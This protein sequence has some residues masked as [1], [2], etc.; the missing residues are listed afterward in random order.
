[1]IKIFKTHKDLFILIGVFIVISSLLILKISLNNDY[2]PDWD[3]SLH[4]WMGLMFNKDIFSLDLKAL[5]GLFN[6]SNQLYPPFY[7][8][9]L[10]LW[11]QLSDVKNATAVVANIPFILIL[12]LSVYGL[13]ITLGNKKAGLLAAILSPLLPI[14]ITLQER[15]LIDYASISMFILSFYILFKT[16]GFT[17]KKYSIF[18][19][20]LILI[21]LLIKWPF[22]I[23]AIPFIFYAIYNFNLKKNQRKLIALNIFTSLAI[24]IPG[25]LWYLANYKSIIDILSFFWKPNG[26]AMSVWNFPHGLSFQNII[27]YLYTYPA[28][29]VGLIVLIFFSIQFLIPKVGSEIKFINLSILI[30]FFVLTYLN[31]K[32]PFYFGYAYPLLMITTTT[33]LYS[34][35][36]KKNRILSIAIL[37]LAILGNYLLTLNNTHIY[38]PVVLNLA[39]KSLTVLPNYNGKFINQKW[40]TQNLVDN[41][42]EPENCPN[43][44]LVFPDNKFLNTSNIRYYLTLKGFVMFPEPAYLH[45]N[46]VRDS[47]FNLEILNK[48]SCI[49][50][51]SGDPG[52]FANSKVISF[53]NNYLNS[54]S[55]YSKSAVDTPDDNQVFIYIRRHDFNIEIQSNKILVNGGSFNFRGV[56]S[57][58]FRLAR[59][60]TY[61][62]NPNDLISS[63]TKIQGWD[64][65]TLQFYVNPDFFD[66]NSP[67]ASIYFSELDQVI[68]WAYQNNIWVILNPV[69]DVPWNSDGAIR[70]KAGV[71]KRDSITILLENL[72]RKF[73]NYPNIIFGIEA[74]PKF[75]DNKQLIDDRIHAIR[76]YS[77][78]PI[79]MPVNFF[80]SHISIQEVLNYENIIVDVHHY[81]RRSISQ[82]SKKVLDLH[83]FAGQ[84]IYDRYPVVF[85]ELGGFWEKDFNTPEDILEMERVGE[86]AKTNNISI[87]AYALDDY[88][89][90]LFDKNGNINN[91]GLAIKK[92]FNNK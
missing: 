85:G 68:S 35:R 33:K 78:N 28:S 49:V 88:L 37:T 32:S 48:Y 75:I 1:M 42:L 17:N 13:G 51:K 45:Y 79:L 90:S 57:N 74:E 6:N 4:L 15:A 60:E 50:T 25:I 71:S 86:L 80:S 38:K 30:T 23:P 2:V 82:P 41:F 92:L 29:S 77:K 69:N 53:V 36:S 67:N 11:Y 18:F 89:I 91:R 58:Y 56:T 43:G 8:I 54:N 31:D 21:D 39:G 87:I 40:P 76:V 19:G 46:P 24:T 66:L 20:I 83:D 34:V 47:E 61:F 22:V 72:S 27:L 70:T 63:I 7:Y 59:G 9:I 5:I 52:L 44:I 3:E 12:M 62:S 55:S 73:S 26:V 16:Q 64:M 84:Y 10:G 81:P 14:F 65:N